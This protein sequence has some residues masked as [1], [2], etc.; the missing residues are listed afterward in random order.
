MENRINETYLIIGTNLGDKRINLKEAGKMIEQRIGSIIQ[1]SSVYETE[2][3]GIEDQPTF[4]N[5]VLLVQTKLDATSVLGAISKIETDM[6]RIRKEKYG[7]RVI[8]IDILF[9]NNDIYDS[10]ALIVPHPRITERNFVLAPLAEIAGNVVHP[11]LQKS[12]SEL[13]NACNDRLSVKKIDPCQTP[14]K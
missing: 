8:D 11:I 6:G 1:Q 2:P 4:Y 13:W 3:W 12:I 10:A 7:S 14:T 9:F 5:Q